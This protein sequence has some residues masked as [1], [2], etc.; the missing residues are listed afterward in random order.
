MTSYRCG[1][2]AII[3]EWLAIQISLYASFFLIFNTI[4]YASQLLTSNAVYV[5]QWCNGLLK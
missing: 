1:S 5:V 4:E 2:V 3:C